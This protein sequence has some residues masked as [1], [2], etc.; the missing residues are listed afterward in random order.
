MLRKIRPLRERERGIHR[1]PL[2]SES[3][4]DLH[5]QMSMFSELLRSKGQHDPDLPV[6]VYFHELIIFATL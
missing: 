3:R 2:V 4:K 6:G 1:Y 5:F